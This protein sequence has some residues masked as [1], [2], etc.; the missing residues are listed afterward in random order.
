MRFP[1]P[2]R[3]DPAPA[4]VP[5]SAEQPVQLALWAS[6]ESVWEW[7]A[8]SDQMRVDVAEGTEVPFAGARQG[9]SLEQFF[10]RAHPD[11]MAAMRLAWQIGRAHV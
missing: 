8:A 3:A 7:Q 9:M 1:L 6:G 10:G 5:Q 2:T 11:D 4:A